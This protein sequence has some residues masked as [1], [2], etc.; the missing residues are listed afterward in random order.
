FEA[1]LARREVAR[2]AREV[3]ERSAALFRDELE[4]IYRRTV[5][6]PLLAACA[7]VREE[8]STWRSL[9]AELTGLAP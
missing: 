8:Y 6:D 2:A 1:A 4:S 3:V 9:Q 7:A 5:A